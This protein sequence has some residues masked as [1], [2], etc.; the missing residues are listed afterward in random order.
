MG[1]GGAGGGG[2]APA[3]HPHR[4]A[5]TERSALRESVMRA[6]LFDL[7]QQVKRGSPSRTRCRA[8]VLSVIRSVFSLRAE[9]VAERV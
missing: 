1:V 3:A 5:I 6:T 8:S 2:T 7:P 4:N 9:R